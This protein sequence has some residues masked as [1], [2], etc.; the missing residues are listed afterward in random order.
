[1]LRHLRE[2][3]DIHNIIELFKSNSIEKF[4]ILENS[5]TTNSSVKFIARISNLILSI[6]STIKNIIKRLLIITTK[7]SSYSIQL[8]YFSKDLK[9]TSSKLR[10]STDI[11]LSSVQET[12][13]AL[14][15][16]ANSSTANSEYISE[17]SNKS[18]KISSHISTNANTLNKIAQVT[19]GLST[20]S[21][22]MEND[23]KNL[24]T[25][26]AEIQKL[27]DG[28]NGIAS[29]T[30][31]LA[32]N[33]SIEAA[34]AGEHG[35]GFSVVADEV[36]KLSETTTVQLNNMKNFVEKIEV[37]SKE[38]ITS[39]THTITSIDSMEI[40][41]KDMSTIFE[42]TKKHVE[43]ISNDIHTLAS[44]MEEISAS[45]EEV[46]SA[47][48]VVSDNVS[49]INEESINIDSKAENIRNVRVGIDELDTE[50]TELT[51]LSSNLT[52]HN[53]FS[54]SNHDFIEAL[55]SAISAHGSWVKTL[56]YMS[57]NMT[58]KPLQLDSNKCGFGHFYNSITPSNENI[59]EIW[60]NIDVLHKDFHN[61][62]HVVIDAIKNNDKPTALSTTKKAQDL[63]IKLIS[64]LERIKSLAKN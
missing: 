38:S 4:K 39:V 7:V 23:M 1:M 12:N 57:E 33:A 30:N 53:Y 5:S 48:E 64:M 9:S 22:G 21:R 17:L 25:L 46:N 36:K 34:R 24:M 14:N 56:E 61:L 59:L 32:L 27:M 62:G 50:I 44:N 15:E 63:S 8:N 2:N 45:T 40:Y 55:D 20:E 31:L 51:K 54:L 41:T 37:A 29:Q 13:S 3:K 11:L 47:M 49:F 19:Q 52:K 60:K 10:N 18:N 35:K 43:E 6:S 26:V 42:D 16:I 58:L 28:I